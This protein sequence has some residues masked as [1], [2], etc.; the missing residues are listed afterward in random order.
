MEC[1]YEPRNGCRNET[2]VNF[3][4]C[5]PHLN[6]PRGMQHMIDTARS[7]HMLVQSDIDRAIEQRTRIP[8]KDAQTTALEKMLEALDRVLEFEAFAGKQ[9]AKLDPVDWR[10]LDRT[11]SEQLRSEVQIYERA[12][13]RTARVLKDIS[14]MALQEKIVGLGKAQTELIIRIMMSAVSDMGLDAKQI[15][16]AKKVLLEKL[17]GEAHMGYRTKEHVT[18]ALTGPTTIDGE[19]VDES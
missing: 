10:F 3:K 13:E 2:A 18:A 5:I 11:G 6:T 19:V 15:D 9:M 14:K 17:I 4:F 1:S 7:G 12:M 16:T 8:E